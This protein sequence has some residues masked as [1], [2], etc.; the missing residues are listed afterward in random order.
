M[1][2]DRR[3]WTL[4]VCTSD[5]GPVEKGWESIK[6]DLPRGMFLHEREVIL[7]RRKPKQNM[8]L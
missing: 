7:G 2:K 5:T 8:I 6:V 4:K 1:L 3:V